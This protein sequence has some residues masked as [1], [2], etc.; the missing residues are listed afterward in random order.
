MVQRY[1]IDSFIKDEG[2]IRLSYST[3]A[4]H[5]GSLTCVKYKKPFLCLQQI[6]WEDNF[7]NHSTHNTDPLLELQYIT[8]IMTKPV[9]QN[10]ADMAW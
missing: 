7:L 4:N 1:Q 2:Q 8:G 5:N 6:E 9:P 10:E 3:Y